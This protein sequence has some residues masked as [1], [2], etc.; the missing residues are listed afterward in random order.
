M[1]LLCWKREK[2]IQETI[3]AL[4]S[5]SSAWLN[6]YLPKIPK[7]V[8]GLLAAFN[9]GKERKRNAI[10]MARCRTDEKRA[11]FL[12]I[13]AD[14]G[15]EFSLNT[16]D[17]KT[18]NSYFVDT[19]GKKGSWALKFDEALT[20]FG[21]ALEEERKISTVMEDRNFVSVIQCFID[22]LDIPKDKIDAECEVYEEYKALYDDLVNKS[23]LRPI[24]NE[25]HSLSKIIKTFT[26]CSDDENAGKLSDEQL[27]KL[28]F[29]LLHEDALL[30][31]LIKASTA[32]F[33]E[34]V[35]EHS[36]LHLEEYQRYFCL[37]KPSW[38]VRFFPHVDKC[39]R[40]ESSYVSKFCLEPV[41][42]KEFQINPD[43]EMI[44]VKKVKEWNEIKSNHLVKVNGLFKGEAKNIIYAV[45]P[46]VWETLYDK[47]LAVPVDYKLALNILQQVLEA[48]FHIHCRGIFHGAVHPMTILRND[49]KVLLDLNFN[50]S[51]LQDK[52]CIKGINFQVPDDGG[53]HKSGDMYGFGCLV[54][55]VLFPNLS[56]QS[57]DQGVPDINA[58]QSIIETM[59]CTKDFCALCALLN[60]NKD[61]RPSS[62]LLQSGGFLKNLNII[63]DVSSST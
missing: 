40:I 18:D 17:E 50:V 29:A 31:D 44:F 24:F 13:Y 22:K 46:P 62:R 30:V 14:L 57:T 1:I 15:K 58:F 34:L 20:E 54:L 37:L 10:E 52:F 38:D 23:D 60:V 45:L 59:L 16:V 41:V 5:N 33:P 51:H 53:L 2:K 11:A 28:H 19:G 9:D 21:I 61:I 48:L 12:T 4:E 7:T 3:T 35:R 42:I 25:L 36:E 32:H 55:W 56:F 43:S 63:N 6:V 26:S 39:N 47:P 27:I 8:E 49:D